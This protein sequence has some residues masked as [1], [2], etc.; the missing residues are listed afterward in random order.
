[1]TDARQQT[2]THSATK[3]A[4]VTG[5]SRGIG[6]AVSVALACT[7]WRVAV[8]YRERAEEAS[9]TVEAIQQQGGDARAYPADVRDGK[10]MTSLAAAVIA[11]WQRLDLVVCN[12]GIGHS[13]LVLRT[14]PEDW[15][16]L[17]GVNLTGTFHTL[18]AAGEVMTARGGGHI[19]IVG[20]LAGSQ[21]QTGQAAYAA[22]KAGLIALAR[23]AA[24]EWGRWNVQVNVVLPGWH[25]TEL[26]GEAMPDDLW[27]NHLVGRTPELEEV[28]HTIAH[29]ATCRDVSGQVWNLDSRVL[30]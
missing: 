1:M 7:G 30:P 2:S 25:R 14:D 6:R 9:R 26:S 15:N 12:A 4:W 19:I 10:Q 20:S 17:V 16:R 23:S 13:G 28:A 11:H 18:R 5:A 22:S 29:L 3:V 24:R 8:H 21:G 27:S